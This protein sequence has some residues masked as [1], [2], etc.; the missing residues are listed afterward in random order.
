MDIVLISA[1]DGQ[2][3]RNL[4]P[5][6]DKDRGFE[7][8]AVPGARWNT[9][10]WMSWSP[11]G[12]RLAYFAR[13][14]KQRSLIVQN[15]VTDKTEVRV[16]LKAV[17][18][19][20]SPDWSPDGKTIYFSALKNGIGDIWSIDPETKQLT[21]LTQDDF[22]DYAPTCVAGR[23]VAGLPGPRQRQQQDLP[24]RSRRRAPRRS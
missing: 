22:A 6:F 17:D 8:I 21:N 1:K 9:V 20:E 16:E 5:G 19:P 4:T 12:D 14:E 18:V 13:T 15:V 2:V 10:P 23:Q 24:A 7:Y 11:V 3:I